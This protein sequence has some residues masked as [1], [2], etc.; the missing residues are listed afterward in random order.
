M[1][2]IIVL[3]LV[4]SFPIWVVPLLALASLV[5]LGVFTLGGKEISLGL[6]HKK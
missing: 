2:Q 1:K 4:L 3:L 6:E 5:Y